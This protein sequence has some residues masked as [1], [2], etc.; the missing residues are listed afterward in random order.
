MAGRAINI[1]AT[2]ELAMPAAELWLAISNT[3]RLNKTT[4]LPSTQFKPVKRDGRVSHLR[5]KARFL[6]LPVDW[7]E[8]PFEWSEQQYFWV[9]RD[10]QGLAGLIA[11]KV[12]TGARMRAI[13]ADRVEAE[14]FADFTVRN[15]VGRAFASLIAGKLFVNRMVAA[16]RSFERNYQRRMPILP[17]ANPK[18][19]VNSRHLHILSNTLRRYP[20]SA[21]LA[22]RLV[23]H[24]TSV[25]DDAV[26]QMRP[27]ALADEWGSDR[28][29][30]L[31]L[32]LYATK[33]GLLDMSWEVLCPNCRVAKASYETLSQL[34]PEA[35][36][37]TCNI[38]YDVN[39]DEYVE[40]RFSVS[41]QVRGS[42]DTT[43][44]IGGPFM[45]RHIIA[46]ARLATDESKE[47]SPQLAPGGYRLRLRQL[48]GFI[49]LQATPDAPAE[50]EI[51]LEADALTCPPTAIGSG[52]SRIRLTNR[53]GQE[54]LVMLE[55]ESWDNKGVSAA[56][57]TSLQEFRD[58]FSSEVLAPGMSV[59]VRNLTFLFSDLKD[60]THLYQRT[61]DSPAYA[62]V[63]DHFVALT[64]AIAQHD[65]SLVKT[66]GDAVMAVFSQPEQAVAAA[67][68]IQRVIGAA[69]AQ[70]ASDAQLCVKLGLHGGPCLAVTANDALD[71]FGSTV[72]LA[73]RVQSTSVGGDIVLTSI[74]LDQPEVREM[75]RDLP[76]ESFSAKLKGVEGEVTLYRVNVE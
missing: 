39:F 22:D 72:N 9:E 50:L 21:K 44:C 24:V 20:V 26:V 61:G 27:F 38:R 66:M 52:E 51:A 11:D 60:S 49:K 42:S 65:G 19:H 55:Q 17:P 18:P 12:V 64:S 33:A 71:Y 2:V 48:P 68:D 35:H 34:K 32:F 30:T 13:A 59:A 53:A 46:Q 69:N 63:R 57:A 29:E 56:L 7:E 54:L 4:G 14:L 73:A 70:A 45:T 10:Y 28:M 47:I 5:A 37:D 31:R 67:L 40:L 76:I 62:R 43:Y 41:P 8:K 15:V 25:P 36:C 75:L 6:G 3:D 58:T 1:K 23:K 16:C 74:L